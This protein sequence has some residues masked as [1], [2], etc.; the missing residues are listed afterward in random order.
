MIVIISFVCYARPMEIKPVFDSE[1]LKSVNQAVVLAEELVSNHYK[2][3]ANQWLRPR[4]DIKTLSDLAANE[5]IDGPFAQIIRYEGKRKGSPLG[6]NSYDFYKICLQDHTILGTLSGCPGMLLLPFLVYILTH[7]LI[8]IVR[9]S[10][11]LQIF[12]ASADEKLAEERRVHHATH[13]VL[14]PVRLEGLDAVLNYFR[15]W[16]MPIETTR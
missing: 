9:F 12:E 7:E 6:S 4:F 11:F 8:H 5:V 10:K 13:Q 2:M 16:R 14:S 1:Q 15:L 3:S